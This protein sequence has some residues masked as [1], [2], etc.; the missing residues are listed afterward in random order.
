MREYVDLE[1]AEL[2]PLEDLD[3][4]KQQVFYLLMHAVYKEST[5]IK[6]RA[7][8]DASAKSSTGV[9]L[10]DTLGYRANYTPSID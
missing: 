6:I 4:P 3:K 9:S 10:N 2:V 5:T 1:H 7:V 8:F